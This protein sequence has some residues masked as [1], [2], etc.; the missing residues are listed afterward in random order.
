MELLGAVGAD[1]GACPGALFALL[2]NGPTVMAAAIVS[3]LM[4]TWVYGLCRYKV[5]A[6]KR[7]S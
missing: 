1:T 3:A 7:A 6:L 2:G 5:A 4:G